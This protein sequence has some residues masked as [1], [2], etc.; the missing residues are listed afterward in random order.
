MPKNM[1]YQ[2]FIGPMPWRWH[3]RPVVKDMFAGTWHNTSARLFHLFH[4]CLDGIRWHEV[5]AVHETNGIARS[6]VKPCLPRGAK[7]TV[8]L[9]AHNP[10]S[11]GHQRVRINAPSQYLNAAVRTT[12]VHKYELNAWISLREQTLR[13]LLYICLHPIHRYQNRNFYHANRVKICI[14]LFMGVAKL[15]PFFDLLDIKYIYFRN[16]NIKRTKII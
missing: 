1:F 4:Q 15:T 16:L 14:K 2:Q 9:M 5:V 12:I 13:A 8:S 6:G 11:R 7:P 3:H 10:H